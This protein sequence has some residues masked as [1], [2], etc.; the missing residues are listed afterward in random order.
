MD[1]N[2]RKCFKTGVDKRNIS[3]YLF[4]FFLFQQK[5]RVHPPILHCF[6]DI[7]LLSL[8]SRS[9]HMLFPLPLSSY[10]ECRY[11]VPFFSISLFFAFY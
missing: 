6:N 11:A 9:G 10:V 1:E 8:F 3:H 2:E 5:T 7:L 4:I